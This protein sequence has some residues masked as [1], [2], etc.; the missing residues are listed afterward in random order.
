MDCY[1]FHMSDFNARLNTEGFKV[2]AV[3][4]DNQVVQTYNRRAYYKVSLLSGEGAIHFANHAI[5]FDGSVLVI[6]KPDMDCSWKLTKSHLVSYTCVFTE[7]FSKA[8]CFYWLDACDLFTSH[9]AP[10]FV[11]S[12][13]QTRFLASIFQ[14]MIYEQN[15]VYPFKG[16]LIQNQICVLLHAALKMTP[17]QNFV[18]FNNSAPGIAT[19]FVELLEMQLPLEAQVI[20]WN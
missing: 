14:K 3:A 18:D 1:P 17:S 2:Y 4:S 10:V 16:D 7:D 5:E 6:A 12:S 13:E 15:I 8:N 11:L 9:Q 19:L 20:H